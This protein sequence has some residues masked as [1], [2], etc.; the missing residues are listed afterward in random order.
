LK[1][2]YRFALVEPEVL[3]LEVEELV[4]APVLLDPLA[5]DAPLVPPEAEV[6]EVDPAVP[7]VLCTVKSVRG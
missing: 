7:L 4:L 6:P 2:S 1:G 5:P 3:V